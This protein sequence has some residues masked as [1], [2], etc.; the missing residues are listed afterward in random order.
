MAKSITHPIHCPDCTKVLY[1]DHLD[2]IEQ[3]FKNGNSLEVIC[4]HCQGKFDTSIFMQPVVKV[5][6]K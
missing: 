5:I 3:Y 6:K 4:R 2:V 1:K